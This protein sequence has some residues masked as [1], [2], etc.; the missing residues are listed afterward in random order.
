M[1]IDILIVHLNGERIIHNCL[2]SIYRN[3][4]RINKKSSEIKIRVLLNNSVDKSEEII[5][6]NFPETI[7]YKTNKT[8]GFAEACDFL[9]K[10]SDAEYIIFLNNDTEVNKNWVGEMLKTIKKH[11]K[12]VACQP[13]IKSYFKK[14]YFEYAGAAGGFIDIYGYPFCRGRVFGNIEEDKGQYNDERRIFW[15]CGVC[16]LVKRDFFIKIGGFDEDFFMYAE[17]LDFCWRAN[18]YGKEIWFSPNSTIYHIGSYSIK[19]SNLSIKDL[20]KDY[21]ITRN[22]LLAIL[23]NYS[24]KSLIKIM[25][26]RLFLEI[27]AAIRFA[28]V[29]TISFVRSLFSLPYIYIFKL[30]KYRRKIQKKR[31]VSDESLKRLI[32]KESI[33][34][35]YFINGKKTFNEVN[36]K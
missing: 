16:L 36:F 31:K 25:P 34:F 12:C 28:P 3:T 5:K 32:L 10:K 23:K 15:G 29:R 26:L 8:I 7:I 14:N 13:K 4:L 6:R 22:H 24:L 18:I 17:E 21:L 30:H 27:V 19:H 11:P 1:T 20:K 35:S 9:A 33:I 2:N